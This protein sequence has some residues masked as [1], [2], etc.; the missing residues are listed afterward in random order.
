MNYA[1]NEMDPT[2]PGKLW[3]YTNYDCNLRCSYCV[4]ESSPTAPR[5]AISLDVVKRLVEEAK[6]AG[7]AS[8]FFTGGEPLILDEIFEML[9]Y[10]SRHLQTILLTN[11]MLLNNQ[12]LRK[13]KEIINDNLIIQVSLDGGCAEH[14]DAYRGKGTWNKTIKGIELLQEN[15][16]HVR[17]ST[18][19]TPANAAHLDEICAYHLS[20]GIPEEDHFIRPLAK[21][22]FSDEGIEIRMDNLAPEITANVDG[23]Y[24]HPLATR[25]NMLVTHTTF[26]LTDALK[27]VSSQLL[28]YQQGESG[29][30]KTFT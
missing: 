26:P 7:I 20:I 28:A 18:T 10:S 27:I 16:F 23:I 5:R 2:K 1:V 4:A 21:C 24:W 14:H 30:L 29:P 19:E 13:L 3:I 25:K 6:Q 12:R 15:G 22:G 11:A 9:A 8:V 17:L